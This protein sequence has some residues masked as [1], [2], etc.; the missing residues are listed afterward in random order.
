MPNGGVRELAK[1][2]THDTTINLL[3]PRRPGL[4]KPEVRVSVSVAVENFEIEEPARAEI[5]V[6]LEGN[7]TALQFALRGL[8]PGS[9]RIMLDFAQDSRPVGS[10]DL[11]PEIIAAPETASIPVGFAPA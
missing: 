1:S 4:T 5:A 6:P 9:G 2:H 11:H 7:S 8:E 10:V 3:S